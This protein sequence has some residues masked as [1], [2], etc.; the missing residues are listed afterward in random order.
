VQD[1]STRPTHPQSPEVR[2]DGDDKDD[3]ASA[4]ALLG[5]RSRPRESTPLTTPAKEN[6]EEQKPPAGIAK[7]TPKLSPKIMRIILNNLTK[8]PIHYHAART[9]GI[10][11]KTLERWLKR[12]EAGHHGY[13]IKWQGITRRFHEHCEWAIDEARQTLEDNWRERAFFGYDKVLTRRGRVI[14][15]IDE[16]LAGLGYEGPDA[17]LRDENGRPVPETI[18]KEDTKAQLH[19]L[20]RHRPETW[21]KRPKRDVL[22]EGGVLV[23]GEVKR[24]YNTDKSVRA[25]KWKADL[26]RLQEEKEYFPQEFFELRY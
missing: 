24:K 21:G 7:S 19:V 18:H 23:I 5:D 9:A 22:R 3:V 17:Y 26:R 4:D 25:K 16:G 8:R 2:N 15:K 1:R 12:S 11:R 20:K 14:Y 6:A 13:D 10:H